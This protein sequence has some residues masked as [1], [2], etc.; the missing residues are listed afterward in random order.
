M[1][2]LLKKKKKKIT[3]AIATNDKVLQAFHLGTAKQKQG[4]RVSVI[5][6]SAV[7]QAKAFY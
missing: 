2:L 5:T 7:K 6:K 3:S 4:G 1:V